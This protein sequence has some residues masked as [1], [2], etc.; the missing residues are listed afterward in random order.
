MIHITAIPAF[1]DN[2]IWMLQRSGST[3]VVLVDPGDQR[4]IM[5]YLQQ[6]QLVP[7]AV[8][9][10][11]QHYDH[12]GGVAALVEK[13]AGLRIIAPDRLPSD[14]PI[15]IDLPITEYVTESVANGD[16]V[17]ISELDIA[18]NVFDIPGH[19]LDHLAYY[20]HGAVFCGDT[21]FGCG[22]GRLF[23]GSAEQMVASMKK[24]ASL[25]ADTRIY[26]G[27]EYTLD[28]IGFA[29]WVEP[30]NDDLLQRDDDDMAQQEQGI[31]TVPFTLDME[32]KTNPFLRYREPLV[33]Q[34]AEK[35]A[36]KKLHSDAEVFAA[37][38]RWKDTEY[39]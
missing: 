25:P 15:S 35:F 32:L 36:G 26:C 30:D 3:S 11:H 19:T 18:F 5:D 17:E 8:L 1:S 2:Y 31:P 14:S 24:L 34:A 38:R 16:A 10:T 22:C 23:S 7:V 27:H 6:K 9:I 37:I 28:N 13:Y 12:T 33:I 39:D 4:R 20:G 29:R 21:I